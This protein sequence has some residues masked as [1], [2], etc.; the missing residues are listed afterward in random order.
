M[1]TK[2]YLDGPEM[3]S[4][5]INF[6]ELPATEGDQ[7]SVHTNGSNF[8][9]FCWLAANG[10]IPPVAYSI[11]IGLLV[12]GWVQDK[13]EENIQSNAS[14][15]I[16]HLSSSLSKD[17]HIVF[18]SAAIQE[19]N[20]KTEPSKIHR[21]QASNDQTLTFKACSSWLWWRV[22]LRLQWTLPVCFWENL[23]WEKQQ[24]HYNRS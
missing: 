24:T 16:Q 12:L 13:H 22:L 17:K 18:M 2:S 4:A 9:Q 21:N 20:K 19:E 5:L 23:Q 7:C 8:L 15:L 11:S 3:H 6:G 14:Y 10:K 1:L